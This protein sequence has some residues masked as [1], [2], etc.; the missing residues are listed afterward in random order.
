VPF[1]WALVSKDHGPIPCKWPKGYFTCAESHFGSNT[2]GLATEVLS[3]VMEFHQSQ[4]E[5]NRSSLIIS[6]HLFSSPLKH[7][8]KT[9]PDALGEEICGPRAFVSVLLSKPRWTVGWCH[10]NPVLEHVPDLDGSF[11]LSLD[12][13]NGKLAWIFK[14]L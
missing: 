11:P 8:Y 6:L 12:T 3:P 10:L 4:E 1:L 14:L 2:N 9:Q 13:T 5:S 7:P